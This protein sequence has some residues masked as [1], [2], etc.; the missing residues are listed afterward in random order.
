VVSREGIAVD[1]GKVKEVLEWK[2]PTTVSEVQSFLGLT[3]YYKRFILSFSKIAKPITELLMKGKKY[4]WSEACDKAFKHLKKLLT[5]SPVLAQP[6]TTEPFDV[7]CDASGTGLGGVLMQEGQ[8]ILYSSRQLRHHEEHYLTHDLELVAVVMALRMWCHYLLGNVV[9]IYTDHKSLKY[10]F[11]EPD[12]NMR[13]RR[14][15]ELIKN[16]ELEVHYHSGKANVVADTLSH[17]ANCNCLPAVRLTGEESSTRVLPNLPLFNI[18]LMPTLRTEIIA[19]QKDDEGMDRI[20]RR[21]QDGDPKVACFHEDAEGTLWFKE[22]LVVPRRE[23]LKKKI[24]DEA[25]T[26]RYSIHPGSTKMYHDLRQQFWWTRMK[27]E[28]ARYVSECDTY[29]KVRADYMKLERLLQPVS[30]PEWKWDDISM[31][32]IVGLPLMAH[33]LDSIWVIVD[34]LSKSAHFIPVHTRY[35]V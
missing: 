2:P 35:N 29:R 32:F 14:W 33:K 24:L 4:V 26:L 21:M 31:N 18:T 19:A 17:K 25:Y 15:L 11:T 10:I 1:P 34:R 13:Q 6:D 3:G 16:Y 30:I 8:V 20:K 12:L 5:T 27:R 23:A 7:Y 28:T 22:R 9:Y